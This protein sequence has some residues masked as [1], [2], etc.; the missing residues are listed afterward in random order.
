MSRSNPSNNLPNPTTRWFEWNGEKGGIRYYDR[1]AKQNIDVP[2]PFQ[3]LLLE[4]L[5]TL[6]GWHDASNSAIHSNEVRDTT[7]EPFVAKAFKGG[8]LVE[9][10]YRDIKTAI[11]AAGGSYVA[12]CYLAYKD[13]K[14]YKLGNLQ[15]KG[16]ALGAWMDF[17]KLHRA[18]L[19]TKAIKIEDFAEG[20][21]GRVVFRVPI[22]TLSEVSVEADAKA[23]ALDEELQAYLAIYFQRNRRDQVDGG[24]LADPDV[25]DA[26]PVLTE[27]DI[28]F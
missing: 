1:E 23:K 9:G 4:E 25:P 15:L 20:K 21:K 18:H 16:A 11:N 14:D 3:Y 17:R 2:L 13:G 10:K 24:P 28:P 26:V 8:T 6:R 22:F 27:E 19:Y 5:A 7:L 12:S